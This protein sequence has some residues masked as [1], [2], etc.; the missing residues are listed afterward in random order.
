MLQV[1]EN[2]PRTFFVTNTLH[3]STI[4]I[5]IIIPIANWI[6]YLISSSRITV[7]S[8]CSLKSLIFSFRITVLRVVGTAA[9]FLTAIR[10]TVTRIAKPLLQ[11]HFVH[12]LCRTRGLAVWLQC[13]LSKIKIITVFYSNCVAMW[14]FRLLGLY[15]TRAAIIDSD[16]ILFVRLTVTKSAVWK[17]TRYGYYGDL[18]II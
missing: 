2:I 17:S 9:N 1:N 14:K 4:I 6:L 11:L 10:T 3:F 5:I 12:F 15:G 18:I 16:I 7:N 8:N 13:T